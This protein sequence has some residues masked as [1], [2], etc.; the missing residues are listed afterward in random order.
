MLTVLT[1]LPN[2]SDFSIIKKRQAGKKKKGTTIFHMNIVFLRPALETSPVSSQHTT[3]Q[4]SLASKEE[5]AEVSAVSHTA[6]MWS[7]CPADKGRI[8]K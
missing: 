3:S 7:E 5:E 4:A 8:Q 6:A 2:P 1:A